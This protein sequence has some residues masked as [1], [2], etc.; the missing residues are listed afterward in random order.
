MILPSIS[1]SVIWSRN[2][3]TNPPVEKKQDTISTASWSSARYEE[4]TQ[5]INMLQSQSVIREIN[6]DNA[7]NPILHRTVLTIVR[8]LLAHETT[9]GT[10]PRS[11]SKIYFFPFFF[12]LFF[13]VTSNIL[14]IKSYENLAHALT[15]ERVISIRKA[16][17]DLLMVNDKNPSGS[18][19]LTASLQQ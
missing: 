12:K 5:L 16:K 1:P 2:N 7:I 8:N 19:E 14:P 3:A 11:M 4:F 6:P 17:E 9:L 13:T 10:V 15:N 18:L